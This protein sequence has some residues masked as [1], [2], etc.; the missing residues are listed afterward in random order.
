MNNPLKVVNDGLIEGVERSAVTPLYGT[1]TLIS[2]SP[3]IGV[4]RDE[5]LKLFERS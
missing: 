2:S 5:F 1:P 3:V 4:A